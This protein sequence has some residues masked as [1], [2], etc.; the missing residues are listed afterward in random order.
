MIRVAIKYI[1]ISIIYVGTG[2]TG[3]FAQ[4][5]KSVKGKVLSDTLK[6]R[7]P[8][9]DLSK[10]NFDKTKPEGDSIKHGANIL[11]LLNIENKAL[12]S[13]AWHLDFSTFDLVEDIAIDS[14]LFLPHLTLPLQKKLVTQSYLGN[15][16]S[17]IQSD[18]FFD[19][20]INSPFLFSKGYEAY[21]YDILYD[22]HFNVKTPHTLL[23][24]ASAGKR[25]DAEQTLRV[26]HTQNVN[27]YLNLGVRYDY[28]NAK[29]IYANQLTRNNIFSVFGSYYKNR[30]SI[31]SMFNYTYIRNKEN[32][33]LED[34]KFVQDTVLE[35]SIIPF[36]LT[37]ASSEFRQRGFK[38]SAGYDIFVKKTPSKHVSGKDTVLVKP[39]LTAKFLFDANRYTRVYADEIAEINGKTDSSYYKNFYINNTTTH[40]SVYLVNYNSTFLIELSQISKFPGLPGLR[41]WASNSTGNYYYFQPGDFINNRDNDKLN[42]NHLGV[43]VYSFSPYLSYAGSL[44]L[45]VN[46]YKSDDKELY[47]QITISPWKSTDM[48]YVKGKITVSDKEPDIFVSNYFSNHYKW[49]NS[50][51]KEKWFMLGGSLGAEKWKFQLGYNLVRI[52]NFIY[53]DAD[54]L[55][56]Q[57]DGIT[58]TSAFAEKTLK[59]GGFHFVNKVLWQAN[60]NDDVLSLP[61]FTFFSSLFYEH[62]LVKNVL[63][64]QFGVSG[65]YRTKFY[66]DAYIPA[67]GLFVNQRE[68]LIGNYPFVDVFVNLK[69]KRAILFFKFDHINQGT[70]NN[71]YF[72][73]LHYPANRRVFKFGLSWMFYN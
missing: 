49:T 58:I 73:T 66:A 10:F 39:L 63:R 37:N 16:G 40:D 47:G 34:D 69:W 30:I 35:A 60:T 18:H 67:T 21:Q 36:R 38:L 33:G 2:S 65:F 70:P 72:T 45:Y 8:T 27:R 43:G 53:F 41:F 29:G 59:L 48:P 6:L 5:Q 11:D 56:A 62:E 24:Y 17:P 55:P 26:L 13:Y 3:S 44:R 25:K 54:G 12:R 51:D 4:E 23:S 68:K 57:V 71:E 7:R 19:R 1:I 31:Q 52:V 46:G 28:Y 9:E 20:N 50:F 61:S 64:G 42:T 22:K 14:V 15:L 32:G